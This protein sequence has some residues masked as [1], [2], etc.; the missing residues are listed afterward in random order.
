MTSNPFNSTMPQIAP[1]ILSADFAKLG[2]EIGDVD[3]G[4]ADFL[5]LDVMDGHFVPNISFGP[6]VTAATRSVTAAFLDVHLMITEPVRY[7]PAFVEA[8]ADALTFHVEVVSD[9]AGTA[10]QLRRLGCR[11]VGVTLNPATPVEQVYPALDDVDHVLV[12]SVVPGFSGQKFMP[13]VLAKC[14]AIK[15][16]LR[17]AQRLQIDGGIKVDNVRRARDAG[18]DWFVVASAI[19]GEPDR[20]AAIAAFRARLAGA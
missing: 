4:G 18:V 7:A 6:A 5:H 11:H 13:E 2:S 15:P 9:V 8:G 12:M 19:F 16:R 10:R 3:R 20:A 14:A 17:P 1:S